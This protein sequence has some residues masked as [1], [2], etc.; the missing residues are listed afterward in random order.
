MKHLILNMTPDLTPNL[1]LKLTPK[2]APSLFLALLLA[3]LSLG[4]AH[5]S[6]SDASSSASPSD[7]SSADAV[8]SGGVWITLGQPA[9]QLLKQKHPSLHSVSSR[10]TETGIEIKDKDKDKDQDK[11]KDKLAPDSVYLVQVSESERDDLMQL[12]HAQLQHCAG[13]FAYDSRTAALE[14]LH[15]PAQL[16]NLTRPNY[17]ITHQSMVSPMLTQMTADNIR[18]TILGLTAF[19]N[20]YYNGSYGADAANWLVDNWTALAGSRSDVHV[21]KVFR[22]SDAMPSVVL[23]IDGLELA[24]QEVV[25]GAHLDS[26]N[27]VDRVG[28]H[29]NSVA[30]GADDDA[31]G[32]AGLTEILRLLMASNFKPQ[33]T[34]KLMAYSGEEFGLFG[35]NYIATDYANR[36]VDVVGVLQLDMTNYQGSVSDIY[37]I[38]DYTDTQ[39]NQFLE[40]LVQTYLPALSVAHTTCGYACSDHASWH[41]HGYVASFPFEALLSQG[42]PA[43][44]SSGDTYAGSGN[45]AANALK[46]TRLGLAY[47][48]ELG[49]MSIDYIFDGG[50]ETTLGVP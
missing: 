13:F 50:F 15:A 14:S 47:A 17:S 7:V 18:D 8:P 36:N 23:T 48:V 1:T 31:S 19:R 30:P 41:Q 44:H 39:Q 5:A 3:L 25:L 38:D 26:V 10:R 49:K 9:W 4:F 21:Q 2:I 24:G 22:G 20:R 37:L 43:I 28:S 46:F 34:I 11:Y 40:N 42:N 12:V 16:L 6:P 29:R 32:V 27:V 35:S 45:Q 33:R